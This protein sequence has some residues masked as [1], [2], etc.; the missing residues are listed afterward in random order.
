MPSADD[1]SY[2]SKPSPTTE[3]RWLLIVLGLIGL[4][5]CAALVIGTLIAPFYVPDHDWIADTISDLAAGRWEIMMDVAL[6]G[7]GAGLMATSLA[8]SHAHLGKVGWSVG[9]ISLSILAALVVIIGARNEYGDND[10]EGV[11]I[12]IYLVYGLGALFTVVSAV[13]QA[14]LRAS[15]HD[16]AG[17]WLIGLGIGWAIMS[18]VFLMSPTW[19]DGLL[20]R[21]LGLFA[22][23]MVVTLSLV[24]LRRG[25]MCRSE[26]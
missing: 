11:V 6:Y 2:P 24:F 8:A 5:G 21:F 4:G 12:H 10:N 25:L 3:H 15:G 13:M 20:E 16:R 14:G 23:A 7:F 18:P 19:I 1:A 22:C 17:K 26:G 9:I